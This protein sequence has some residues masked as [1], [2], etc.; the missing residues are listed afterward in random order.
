MSRASVK[1]MFLALLCLYGMV[2]SIELISPDLGFSN[3]TVVMAQEEGA[4]E[5][6][7]EESMLVWLYKA[8]GIRYVISFLFLSFCFVALLVMNLLAA[9]RDA[10]CPAH[11]V[12]AFEAHLAEK[13]YQEAYEMAKADESMLGK[14]LAA[15]LSSLSKGYDH[16]IE[17]MQEVGEDENMKLEHRLSY[18]ALIGTIAPMVGLLGTVDG[19]VGSFSVIAKSTA[20]PKPSELATGISMA[21][22]TTLV[23]LVLA[24]PA[25]AVFNIL[26]NRFARLVLETG[27][28]ST[29]LMDRFEQQGKGK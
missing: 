23:G 4:P 8:L 17:A 21:L 26:K 16:A 27:I 14:V 12:E 28:L 18:L 19:M 11:L 24:I 10:I 20:T 9:R 25:L 13:R 6:A 5:A 1:K 7:Q 29:G 3:A 2:A 15:G 22:I